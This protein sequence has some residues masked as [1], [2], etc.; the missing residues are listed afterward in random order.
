MWE[1]MKAWT[2]ATRVKEEKGKVLFLRLK[3]KTKIFEYSRTIKLVDALNLK[4]VENLN[5]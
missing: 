3:V 1:E 2:T 4:E 5:H